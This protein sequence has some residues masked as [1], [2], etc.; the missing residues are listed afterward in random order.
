M[1]FPYFIRLL[2]FLLHKMVILKLLDFYY[3]NQ[4]LTSTAETLEYQSFSWN[5]N[6]KYLFDFN[7]NIYMGLNSNFS[8]YTFDLCISK[9]SYRNSSTFTIPTSH[10]NQLPKHLNTKF[11]PTILIQL[12]HWISILTYI[13][14]WISIFN[15]TPLICASSNGHTE[16]V[17][18]LLSQPGIEINCKNI[19]MQK[20]FIKFKFNY[21]RPF[22]L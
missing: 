14:N 21:L 8:F 4:S 11:I 6:L 13:W 7:F 16:I 9:R 17:Q 3:H 20:S 5:Y 12:F 18:L 19:W 10:W 2:W 22:Q 1:K 15:N